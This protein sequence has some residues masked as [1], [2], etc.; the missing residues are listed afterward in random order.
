MPYEILGG[1]QDRFV[2]IRVTG[3]MSRAIG[4]QSSVEASKLAARLGTHNF[5]YDVR[6][7]PNTETTVANYR[8][9]YD[10]LPSLHID[11][12]SRAALLT[13]PG[14]HSHDF[15]ETVLQNAGYR[16]KLF[17]DESLAIAWLSNPHPS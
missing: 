10:D 17:T 15:I 2:T 11:R 5:L 16:V 9:A 1:S 8:F 12:H 13:S 7:A 6:N 3:A 4:L 14:D